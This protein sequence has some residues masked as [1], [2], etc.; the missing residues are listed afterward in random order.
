MQI[1]HP[2]FNV[3]WDNAKTLLAECGKRLLMPG[4]PIAFFAAWMGGF[5]WEV[6]ASKKWT[7][8]VNSMADIAVQVG[9]HQRMRD[10]WLVPDAALKVAGTGAPMATLERMG[11]RAI[12]RF[13]GFSDYLDCPRTGQ[14]LD[15]RLRGVGIHGALNGHLA[16]RLVP[17]Y[18]CV[19]PDALV[20]HLTAPPAG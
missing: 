7:N 10:D 1:S 9:T 6:G 11:E 8:D 19:E 2:R 4:L 20:M 17:V 5:L 13:S 3:T 18:Q 15:D 12:L 14:A 16:V